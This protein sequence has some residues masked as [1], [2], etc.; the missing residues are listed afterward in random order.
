VGEEKYDFK[1]A[2]F[3]TP[4]DGGTG[5]PNVLG[6][7]KKPFGSNTYIHSFYSGGVPLRRLYILGLAID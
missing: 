7:F 4:N 6:V 2:L 5:N 3:F 1:F